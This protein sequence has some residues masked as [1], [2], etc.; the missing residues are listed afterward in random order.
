MSVTTYRPPL[1]CTIIACSVVLLAAL[2]LS[3]CT[4]GYWCQL[5]KLGTPVVPITYT[6]TYQQAMRPSCELQRADEHCGSKALTLQLHT[7]TAAAAAQ[8]KQGSSSS[9]PAGA[10]VTAAI[11]LYRAAFGCDCSDTSSF[12]SVCAN[13]MTRA[14]SALSA[15]GMSPAVNGHIQAVAAV[16]QRCVTVSA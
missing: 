15:A 10:V 8:C 16:Q 14:S 13:D 5:V 9:S 7:S 2:M 3:N 1:S 12:F 6:C 11:A 4:L